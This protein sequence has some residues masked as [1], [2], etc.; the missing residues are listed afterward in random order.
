MAHSLRGLRFT[1][2][3]LQLLGIHGHLV[4]AADD[5][6]ADLGLTSA[7]WQ[8][9]SWFR[10]GPSTV[11]RV[12]RRMGLSRQGVQRLA[13]RLVADGFVEVRS[14]PDHKRSP[15]L[16][17]TPRGQRMLDEARRRQEAWADRV[18][19]DLAADDVAAAC[20]ALGNVSAMLALDRASD[21]RR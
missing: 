20:R 8:V 3:V 18:G 13:D 6:V 15:L 5:L 7:R 14:N 16:H 12:A 21:H 19:R 4:A 1:E 10:E 17:L 11:S 2:L 9:L